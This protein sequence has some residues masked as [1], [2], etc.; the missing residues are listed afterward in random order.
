VRRALA[1]VALLLFGFAAV[2]WFALES[3][4]VAVAETRAPDGGLRATHVWYVERDGE[5]WLEAGSPENAWFVDVQREPG[6]VLRSERGAAAYVAVPVGGPSGH[7][8]IRALMRAKYG[9]RD[10]WVNLIVDTSRS[11]AVRLEEARS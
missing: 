4:G 9:F 7:D 1:A 11:V 3:S 8:E 10:W 5:L 6:L 2:T